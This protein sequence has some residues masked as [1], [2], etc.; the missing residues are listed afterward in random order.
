VTEKAWRGGFG[1]EWG[2]AS[3]EARVKWGVAQYKC[4]YFLKSVFV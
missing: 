2:A 4:G 3:Y 1:E